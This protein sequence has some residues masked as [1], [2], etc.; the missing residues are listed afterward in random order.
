[1]DNA[2]YHNVAIDKA[3]IST[4]TKAKMMDWLTDWNIPFSHR[5]LKPELYTLNQ[6][7]TPNHRIFSV[8][9]IVKSHG[10]SILCLPPTIL[11][12]TVWAK[13]KEWL[14]V[15][16]VMFKI[17]DVQVLCERRFS[18]LE[19]DNWISICNRVKKTEDGYLEMDSV[20]D[21]I[22]ERIIIGL[23]SCDSDSSDEHEEQTEDDLSGIEELL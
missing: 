21:E 18:D 1:M 20:I 22:Q 13:V 7:N 8:D 23:G 5:M 17:N 10:H 16:N 11:I 6:L 9:K 2:S 14:A 3:P 12:W 4:T 15:R 19:K